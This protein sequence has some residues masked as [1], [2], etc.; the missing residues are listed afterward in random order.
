M[1][2]LKLETNSYYLAEICNIYIKNTNMKFSKKKKEEGG[3]VA[4]A[5]SASSNIE[6]NIEEGI[7]AQSPAQDESLGATDTQHGSKKLSMPFF[8][9]NLRP[10]VDD[11]TSTGANASSHTIH[12]SRSEVRAS[13]PSVKECLG[14]T[15]PDEEMADLTLDVYNMFF[16]SDICSQGFVYS[17]ATLFVKMALYILILVDLRHNKTFPFQEQILV[18]ESVIFAQVRKVSN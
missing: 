17:F 8:Y 15:V 13:R 11:A 1:H 3:D 9:R 6:V 10:S 5:A 12:R 4:D 18:D 2:Q 14:E 16:L 7:I